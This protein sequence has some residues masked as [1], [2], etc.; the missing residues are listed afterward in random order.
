MIIEE[1][2]DQLLM[3]FKLKAVQTQ[4]P[5]EYT[6]TNYKLS[7]NRQISI[8]PQVNPNPQPI[9]P[10]LNHTPQ[11]LNHHIKQILTTT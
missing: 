10:N 11:Y 7:Q 5:I 8:I 9:N 1:G 2:K 3:E 4:T 6:S